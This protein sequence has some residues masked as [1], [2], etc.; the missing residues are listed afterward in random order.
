MPAAANCYHTSVRD[1]RSRSVPADPAAGPAEDLVIGIAA[2]AT[3]LGFDKADSF[4]R[5]R[6]RHPILGETR[7]S[8]GRPAWTPA[9]LRA[10]RTIPGSPAA[11]HE[12]G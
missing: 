5:A 2:A 6:T 3:F 12:P 10:W 4:R 8:D 1:R 11:A 7:T 9:T